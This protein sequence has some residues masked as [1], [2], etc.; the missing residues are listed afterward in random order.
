MEPEPEESFEVPLPR[1]ETGRYLP[2]SVKYMK[3]SPGSVFYII[4]GILVL[5]RRHKMI[6]YPFDL[7]SL[8]NPQIF[9]WGGRLNKYNYKES[10]NQCLKDED[11]KIIFICLRVEILG[12]DHANTLILF[13]NIKTIFRFEPN[14]LNVGSYDY[15][16]L[17]LELEREFN[18]LR[19]WTYV[20]HSDID[21]S[22]MGCQGLDSE[23]VMLR[24]KDD[25]GGFCASWNFWMIEYLI[26]NP[27]IIKQ[28]RLEDIYISSCSGLNP[29]FYPKRPS[30]KTV[31]REYNVELLQE[32]MDYLYEFLPLFSHLFMQSLKRMD[33]KYGDYL[34]SDLF[35]QDDNPLRQGMFLEMIYQVYDQ[36][37]PISQNKYKRSILTIHGFDLELCSQIMEEMGA[38]TSERSTKRKR[39]AR[40]KKKKKKKSKSKKHKKKKHTK[41]KKKRKSK[42][43]KMR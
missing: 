19:D 21:F 22:G 39:D 35:S 27:E 37:E 10:L 14:G 7:Y 6:S 38:T 40:S 42:K 16:N 12:A 5:L 28:G 3:P 29:K 43:S 11:T 24:K 36:L 33:E 15:V 17:D 34:K 25:P 9:R 18:Y 32:C 2:E 30:V 20:K 26:K 41:R 4:M 13:K 31:I 1:L 8:R 23:E